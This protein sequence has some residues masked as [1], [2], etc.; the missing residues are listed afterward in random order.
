MNYYTPFQNLRTLCKFQRCQPSCNGNSCIRLTYQVSVLPF[1][2]LS[3]AKGTLF[4]EFQLQ[5]TTTQIMSLVHLLFSIAIPVLLVPPRIS[6]SMELFHQYT[7]QYT[8]NPMLSLAHEVSYRDSASR[9][10]HPHALK[11]SGN[12]RSENPMELRYRSSA[13]HLAD[14]CP[15]SDQQHGVP[16]LN[17]SNLFCHF[18]ST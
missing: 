17:R 11:M 8:D 1:L 5:S 3:C 10:P 6:F 9:I 15:P 7:R 4:C 18:P 2:P 13:L 12:V 16:P 14:T